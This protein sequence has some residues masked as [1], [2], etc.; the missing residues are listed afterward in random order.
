MTELIIYITAGISS[1]LIAGL[2]G[3]GGGLI[4]VPCLVFLFTFLNYESELIVHLAIGSSLACIIFNSISSTITHIKMSNV[5]FKML[6]PVALGISIGAFLGS[7]IAIEISGQLLKYIIGA[8]ALLIASQIFINNS[9]K[10]EL[11][12]LR[13]YAKVL[14]GVFIGCASSILGIGGGSFSVPFFNSSG[15]D[16]KKSIGTAAAC[17]IPIAIFGTLGFCLLGLNEINLPKYS[18]G[19]IHWPSVLSI[20]ATSIIAAKYGAIL[21]NKLPDTIL[22]N[23]FI[24][25]MIIISLYMF[26]S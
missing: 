3:V 21:A 13:K 18:S 12:N 1:G 20:S 25:L 24:L 16:I 14:A 9:L 2:F 7:A 6:A 26:L 11:L 15:L 10:I 17:G 5:D 4:I 23:L 22:R 19:Y 8:F